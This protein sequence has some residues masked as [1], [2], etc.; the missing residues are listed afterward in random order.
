M[1]QWYIILCTL[2]LIEIHDSHNRSEVEA[3]EDVEYSNFTLAINN[4]DVNTN[5]KMVKQCSGLC[6]WLSEHELTCTIS[7]LPFLIKTC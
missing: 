3:N 5:I 6:V 7:H 4:K 2:M 1:A